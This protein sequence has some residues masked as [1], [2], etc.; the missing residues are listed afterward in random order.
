MRA[1]TRKLLRDLWH[2]K[3]QA[4]AIALV[5][6]SGVAV[7]VMSMSTLESLRLSQATY[8]ERYRFANVFAR[9][10]RA[11][12]PLA[13]RVAEIPGVARVETRVV[14]DV[15]LDVEGMAEPAVGRLVSIPERPTAH[16]NAL[17]LRRGRDI[18]PGHPDEV[19]VSEAFA[20][21]NRLEPGDSVSAVVN[22]RWTRLAIT[23]V[24]L[25]PEYVYQIRGGDLLPDDRHFGV[26]WMGR[27]ALEAALDM[28]GA[29]NDISVTLTRGASEDEVIDRLDRLL[30]RYGGRALGRDDQPSHRYLASE[31]AELR[32]SGLVIPPI[33]LGVAAFLLNVVL[34]RLVGTQRGQIATLK[35]FG[36]S[37]GA[38]AL[39]YLELVSLIVL[40]GAALGVAAG[41]WLGIALTEMYTRFFRFPV[42]E[43]RLDPG[44]TALAVLVSG[45]ASLA[46][47]VGAVRRVAALPPAAAMQPEPPTRFRPTIV[48]RLGFHRWLSPPGRMILRNLE[49]RP[50]RAFVAVLAMSLSVAILVVGGASGDA[51]RFILDVQF[52]RAQRDDV[53]VTL[54]DPRSSRV[55]Q[56]LA[57]LP[58][59][60]YVEPFRAVPATL[61]SGHRTYRTA[62]L[63]LPSNAEL[64]RLVDRELRVVRVPPEGAVLTTQL[65]EMLRVGRGDLLT[66]EALEG[67]RPIRTVVVA[68]LV[69][70]LVGVSAYMNLRALNRL[71]REQEVVS[72]AFLSVDPLDTGRLYRRLKATPGVAGV[73]VREAA[74]ATLRQ[75]LAEAM[76]RVRVVQVVFAVII[77]A[78]VVYNAARIALS[79]R[80]RELA[81]L[82]VVGLTRA[83]ISLILLGEL[84]LLAALAVPP[85]LALGYALAAL[86]TLAYRTELFRLPLV[87][88][89]ST[90]AFAAVVV[91]AAA[92]LSALA[93]RR[94]LDRLDLVAVLKAR[95]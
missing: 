24:A 21:A 44:T 94:R 85:G 18:E 49:R 92:A 87:V 11:P 56:E 72:G 48:E 66:I 68:D 40:V 58:G 52:T 43:F 32:G 41:I 15:V 37:N 63:G 2:L 73:T 59:V 34:A 75:T 67:A 16:L 22:G 61:R 8:Y 82:R 42:L 38:I 76:R 29:F 53:T 12:E 33:F 69:D 77:A 60:T 19:L 62:V 45:A 28:D 30:D 84:A 39:H 50:F 70:E 9:L 86:V 71:M 79:E 17:Y 1:L 7:L 57:H 64:R 23:G 74:L 95:E 46:G 91:A 55:R 93:V 90:Y 35:A 51:V 31:L 25:S 10:K 27:D 47:G 54:A 78:G 6:A 81:T 14:A 89:P 88:A 20:D 5:V 80:S 26:F 13:A 65:A 83:E 3:G 36:Y 4:T